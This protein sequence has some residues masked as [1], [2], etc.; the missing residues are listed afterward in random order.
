MFNKIS[1]GIEFSITLPLNRCDAILTNL[2]CVLDAISVSM[3]FTATF[4]EQHM[5]EEEN[6]HRKLKLNIKILPS[7]CTTVSL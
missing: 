5:S 4:Y 3:K 2:C 1:T 7:I 6:K